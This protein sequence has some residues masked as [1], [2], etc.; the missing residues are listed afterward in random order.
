MKKEHPVNME[1]LNVI[2]EVLRGVLLPI[3]LASQAD[4]LRC[5]AL[6]KDHAMN[7]P[8]IDDRTR[9]MLLDLAEGF[10][11]WAGPAASGLTPDQLPKR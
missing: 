7:R 1:T 6:M 10:D 11:R 9:R 3:A 5:A 8:N 2:Q 4:L